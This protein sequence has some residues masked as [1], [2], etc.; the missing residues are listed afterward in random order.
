VGAGATHLKPQCGHSNDAIISS[1]KWGT[2]VSSSR[3]VP[4]ASDYSKDLHRACMTLLRSHRTAHLL[5]AI[6]AQALESVGLPFLRIDIQDLG[7]VWDG[8]VCGH[9]HRSLV[10]QT[11]TLP[12]RSLH[13]HSTLS[14]YA[15]VEAQHTAARLFMQERL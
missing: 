9:G 5:V 4:C 12:E 14:M 3:V 15:K 7:L 1:R 13:T 6:H 11:P 10:P 8:H 2:L